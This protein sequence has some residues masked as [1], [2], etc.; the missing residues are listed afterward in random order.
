MKRSG[1][2]IAAATLL[3][4]LGQAIN[5]AW[6]YDATGS[7]SSVMTR[8]VASSSSAST[9][10]A[11]CNWNDTWKT[12]SGSILRLYG[13]A[14]TTGGVAS[15]QTWLETNK[16]GSAQFFLYGRD[17]ANTVVPAQGETYVF[18]LTRQNQ[19]NGSYAFTLAMNGT[20]IDS[21]NATSNEV[22]IQLYEGGTKPWDFTGNI[23]LYD[24]ALTQTQIDRVLSTK[25][26][27]C[28]P[29]PTVLALLALG[30]AGVA[31]RRRA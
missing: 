7:F 4:G 31:L 6:S 19:E 25:N 28:L 23:A 9:L 3:C 10:V 1:L 8:G 17:A 20:T 11:V 24:E 30:V 26:A 22:N 18:T 12:N 29:E 13:G 2:T 15:E 27:A 14:I 21:W 5:L 16:N